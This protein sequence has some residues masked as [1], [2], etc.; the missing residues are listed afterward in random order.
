MSLL[1]RANTLLL[2][3]SELL[4]STACDAN[5]DIPD[6]SITTYEGP[7]HPVTA[8]DDVPVALLYLNQYAGLEYDPTV[9]DVHTQPF[10]AGG[11]DVGRILHVGIGMPRLMVVT[12]ETCE[13]PRAYAGLA[14]S[15]GELI[16]EDWRRLNDEEWSAEIRNKPFP[17][18]EWMSDALSE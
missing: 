12:A 7:T 4:I 5:S 8:T 1:S 17:D 18:P 15:Y 9:A 10:D 16:T 11:A 6:G 13:G 3:L 2:L 14:Y